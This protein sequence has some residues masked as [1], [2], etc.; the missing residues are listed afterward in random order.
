[1]NDPITRREQ[2]LSAIAG[3]GGTIPAYPITREEKYLAKAAGQD[4]ELPDYPVSRT[5]QY[6]AVIAEGGGGGGAEPINHGIQFIDYDGTV[7]ATWKSEDVA[8]KTELPDNP[9]HDGLVAQGWNWSLADI[10]GYIADYPK[11]ILT[12]GQMY[13]TESGL[14][15]IDITVTKVTGLSVA[16]KMVGNKNWGDGTEDN[17]TTHTYSDYGNYTITCDGKTIPTY[18]SSAN[19]SNINSFHYTAIRV[20]EN[21]TAI[22]A[23]CFYYCKSLAYVAMPQSVTSIANGAF[24]YCYSLKS[25]TIPHGVTIFDNNILESCYSLESVAI[26]HSVT[27]FGRN[28][29]QN[30]GSLK[31]VAIPHGVTIVNDYDFSSCPSLVSIT[32]PN[33]VTKINST[34]FASCRSLKSMDMPQSVTSILTY[35]FNSNYSTVEYDF[36]NN[37]SVPTLSSTNAFSNINGICKIIVPDALYDEW[38]AATNWATYTD[39]I[40]KA[41]EV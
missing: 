6:L 33:G 35:A 39:Y 37:T 32:M 34:A 38:I 25:V 24:N 31:Y 2:Y 7:V 14:T 40:Y 11:A 19:G 16:C 23:N 29:L 13:K 27:S 36:S 1:M 41:S 21:V 15:E 4:V 28:V 10:N 5:E 12:V 26:P 3:G 20:G 30:C 18:V 9:T 22:I 8:S 17:S